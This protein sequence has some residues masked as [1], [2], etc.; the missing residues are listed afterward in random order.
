MP[1]SIRDIAEALGAQA[2]GAVDLL[3]DRLEEPATAGTNDLAMALNPKFADG[4]A[5]GAA[6]AAVL[7]D[8][9]D[10]EALGLK[11]AITVARPR[12]AMAGL[13]ARFDLGQGTQEGIHPSAV[14]DP[15][16]TI[17]EGV[18]V[19]ALSVIEAGAVI[20]DGSVIGPQCFIGQDVVLG[21]GAIL[22]DHVSLLARVTIGANFWAHSGVRIGGDGFSFVTAEK[23]HVEKTRESL[24]KA[25]VSDAQSWTRIHSVGSVTIGDN[26][27]IGGNSTVDRGT[28]RDTVI[29]NGC[30]IDNLVQIGH[31]VVMGNDCLACAQAGVAGSTQ[32]GNNVVLGGKAGVADNLTI[33]DNVILGAATNA[34]SNVPSG[35]AMMGT[36]AT[37]ME[38]HIEIYKNLRRLPKLVA[39][40]AALKKSVSKLSSKD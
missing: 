25:E 23:S 34:L 38:T 40:M 4:L 24:G 36:P 27:E 18:S 30:K 5:D 35:R 19:G 39:D 11:A 21:A 37:K 13:T 12:Y 7:W 10:W 9:A 8:G 14:I 2:F 6:Q 32:I 16:A 3:V 29:G 33:G 22:R 28:I 15:S 1:Y 17:G 20:G 26:V 31:N